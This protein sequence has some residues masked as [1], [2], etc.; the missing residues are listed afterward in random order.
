MVGMGDTVFLHMPHLNLYDSLVHAYG[1][2]GVLPGPVRV[3]LAPP[4]K[5]K[6]WEAAQRELQYVE[7]P[8]SGTSLMQLRE[9]EK[10]GK[11]AAL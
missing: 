11:V 10:A 2:K 7:I 1:C 8:P 9:L 6:Y 4:L 5:P 3:Y